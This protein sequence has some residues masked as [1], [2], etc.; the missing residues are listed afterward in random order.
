MNEAVEAIRI[1]VVDDHRLFRDGLA[2]LLDDAPD[3]EVVGHAETGA[4]AI[5][6]V[7]EI[8]VDVVLMDILM[9]DMNGI[10]ATARIRADHPDVHVAML[11]M[12]EDDDSLFA[13]M[14]AGAHGY[15]LKGSDTEDVLRT[16]R[17]VAAGEALFGAGIA[18]QLTTFFQH[19]R[20]E[21]LS[22]SPF[23]ELTSR[24][25]EVLDLIAA[26]HD[27]VTISSR[28]SITPKTV[29]NHVTNIFT[30]LQ[31][32]DRAQAIV[33]AREAGLGRRRRV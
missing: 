30:K 8:D 7:G 18:R 20:S 4:E 5:V 28:L 22:V 19:A 1:L 27:N 16:V 14:C 11:T 2:A 31:L 23:P 29:S 13:A 15:I 10:E 32:S 9:P 24:E 12:L 17:A 33:A 6:R 21:G 3:T 25:R 26:G